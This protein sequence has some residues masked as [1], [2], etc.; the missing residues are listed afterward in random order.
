MRSR[1]R[2]KAPGLLTPREWEV[3]ELVRRGM[4]NREIADRL[5]ISLAGA[6]F[7]ISEIISKLGVSSREEAA[8]WRAEARGWRGLVLFPPFPAWHPLRR[9][10]VVSAVGLVAIP[11]VVLI[12]LGI[13][14]Q[15]TAGRDDFEEPLAM[16]DDAILPDALEPNQPVILTGEL[17]DKKGSVLIM[18]EGEMHAGVALTR[19]RQVV[20]RTFY[21]DEETVI[22]GPSRL[23]FPD[24]DLSR[25]KH[26]DSL[27]VTGARQSDGSVLAKEIKVTGFINR[28]GAIEEVGAYYIDVR[29]RW[30]DLP[31]EH[32]AAITR[33]LIDSRTHIVRLRIPSSPGYIPSTSVGVQDIPFGR[34]V[35]IQGT[36]GEDGTPVARHVFFTE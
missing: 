7:H 13:F 23:P 18:D 5:G 20:R 17:V 10:V 25:L 6:K 36:F 34:D 33:F 12:A 31:V 9:A 28:S 30:G 21:V 11:A 8:A 4:S 27:A 22:V 15:K 3:L 24:R 32:D 2:P 26:G 14:G 19:S 1:G 16:A 29:L 35:T